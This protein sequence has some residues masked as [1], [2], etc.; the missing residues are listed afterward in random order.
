MHLITVREQYFN[1]GYTLEDT[2]KV[3]R[4]AKSLHVKYFEISKMSEIIIQL[5]KLEAIWMTTIEVS[6][7]S[8][9]KALHIGVSVSGSTIEGGESQ[10]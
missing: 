5:L 3:L 4:G 8:P 6:L 2:Q 9:V 1:G 10:R 7:E